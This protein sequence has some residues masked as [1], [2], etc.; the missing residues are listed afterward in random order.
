MDDFSVEE[1]KLLAAVISN[2]Q[3]RVSEFVGHIDYK[4]RLENMKAKL[5]QELAKR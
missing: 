4:K 2:E 3:A 1:L 5:F